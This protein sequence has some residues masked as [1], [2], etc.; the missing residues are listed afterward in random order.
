MNSRMMIKKLLAALVLT[1]VAFTAQ[2][3]EPVS[4]SFFGGVAIDG[5]DTVAYHRVKETDPHKAVKG[6]KSWKAEWKGAK[7]LFTTEADRDLFAADP[8]RYAPA[9]NG[10]CANALSLGEGLLKTDGTHWQIFE[11][12]LYTF[13]AARGRDR[14][15]AGDFKE[16]KKD[17]D[18]AWNEIIN[19]Q[20]SESGY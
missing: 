7:W 19:Q 9:Y 11:D 8:E 5:K 13:Y 6:S 15:L 18:K 20:A 2:A 12:K 3:E 4:K 14:W 16:Y 17:A 10:H 1:V